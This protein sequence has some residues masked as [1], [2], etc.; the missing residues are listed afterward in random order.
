LQ[1][2]FNKSPDRFNKSQIS[3]Q[4]QAPKKRLDCIPQWVD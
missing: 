2:L 4:K 1:D 3:V